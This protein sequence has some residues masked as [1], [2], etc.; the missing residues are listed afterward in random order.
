[1]KGDRSSLIW[2]LLLVALGLLFLLQSFGIA[3]A[4]GGAVF[5]VL[6]AAGGVAFL[7][8]FLRDRE[9]WWAVIPGMGLLGLALLIALGSVAPRLEGLLGGPIFLGALGASFLVVYS[10]RPRFWWAIIPGGVLL[11]VAVVAFLD[12]VNVPFDTGAIVLIGMGATFLALT[13]VRAESGRLWW[14]AIPG[15]VLTL[16]GVLILGESVAIMSYLWPALLILA[17]AFF[18]L[19][20]VRGAPRE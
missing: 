13:L 19:R 14:A 7:Y 1:M 6:F 18:V 3:N 4:V 9:R 10:V 12:Q 2:G 8:V 20:S 15:C 16:I 11:S 17:G 5:W